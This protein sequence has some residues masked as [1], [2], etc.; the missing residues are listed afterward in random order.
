[1]KSILETIRIFFVLVKNGERYCCENIQETALKPTIS[2][3]T[4]TLK[5]MLTFKEFQK[6]FLEILV[7]YV[8]IRYKLHIQVKRFFLEYAGLELFVRGAPINP[9]LALV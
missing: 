6:K 3:C 8:L 5:A 2:M 7:P 9:N 1:M 4:T